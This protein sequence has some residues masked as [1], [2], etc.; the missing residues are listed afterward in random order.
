MKKATYQQK[1]QQWC[2][3]ATDSDIAKQ[4]PS[5]TQ[6]QIKDSF[7]TDLSF[8]TAGIRGL[9]GVGTNRINIYTIARM[10]IA[11]AKFYQTQQAKSVVIGYDTRKN[12]WEFAKTAASIF[13][14]FDLTVRISKTSIPMPFI[15]FAIRKTKADFGVMITASH[16]PSDYNGYKI[17][18]KD[19]I[20]IGDIDC[21]AIMAIK[22]INYFTFP[23][24][25]DKFFQSKKITY[26][27]SIYSQKYLQE[28]IDQVVSFSIPT[29]ST[30]PDNAHHHPPISHYAQPINCI[31]QMINTHHQTSKETTPMT[32]SPHPLYTTS[33]KQNPHSKVNPLKIVFTPLNGTGYPMIP[34][35][36]RQFG[37]QTLIVPQ[38][39]KPDPNFTTC[40]SPNPENPQALQLGIAYAQKK[41]AN[42]LIAT[43]PDADRIGIVV[44]HNHQFVP[45]N[46]NELGLLLA[47]YLLSM[48]KNRI[49]P[50][51]KWTHTPPNP[52][53]IRS[54][55]STPLLDKMMC[56]AGGTT[57]IVPTGFRYIARLVE[58]MSFTQKQ[59]FLIGFEESC[60]YLIGTHTRDKDAVAASIYIAKMAEYYQQKG[61]TLIDRL[62]QLYAEYGHYQTITR[63]YQLKKTKDRQITN[64]YQS[65]RTMTHLAEWTITHKRDYLHSPQKITIT[66]SNQDYNLANQQPT[67]S[68]QFLSNLASTQIS[69][70]N[71]IEWILSNQTKIIFRCS[72]TEPVF[73]VYLTFINL[74]HKTQQEIISAI[75]NLIN[76]LSNPQD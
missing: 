73:K 29:H 4:L 40:P 54:M 22:D 47:D 24:D 64:F 15:S 60:G 33:T 62:N 41:K 39:T 51:G 66:T 17:S 68:V 28:I 65:L 8:G 36:L 2:E 26:L 20:Q 55:V 14:S 31:L 32:N 71:I 1:Y 11:V 25:F 57:I 63:T 38:Q 52:I 42:L 76:L 19:G 50:I 30:Q 13:A 59:Q 58:A 34:R 6:K 70:Q 74:S 3:Q 18:D 48:Q 72:G 5:M 46:G 12:S 9:M 69:P 27:P 67:Q 49:T 53:A 7:G 35:L 16:N 45:L 44:H 10:S 21:K 43:D 56:K 23:N 37:I 61:E 75:N